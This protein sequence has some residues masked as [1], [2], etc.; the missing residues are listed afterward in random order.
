MGTYKEKKTSRPLVVVVMAAWTAIIVV[1]LMWNLYELR[2]RVTEVA[3][4]QVEAA[5]DMNMIYRRWNNEHGGIY[6]EVTDNLK[7]NPYMSNIPERDI[8]TPSGKVLTLINPSFMMRKVHEFTKTEHGTRE[9]IVSLAPLNP[10]NSPDQ[11]EAEVLKS[12]KAGKSWGVSAVM[13][14][15][16]VEQMRLIRPLIAEQSCIRCHKGQG[17]S[18]G[19][20]QGAISIMLPMKPL[21][22]TAR[23]SAA[24]F[25]YAHILLWFLGSGSI[26]L[27][28]MRLRRAELDRMRMADELLKGQKLESLGILAGG[29][30]HDYNNLLTA[31]M[32]NISFATQIED[33]EFRVY[34]EKPEGVVLE[35]LR[36]AERATLQAKELTAQLITF[37]RGGMPVKELLLEVSELI[38]DAAGFASRGS[39]VRCDLFTQDDLW[40]VEADKSQINQV[41]Q[42]LIINAEQAMLSGGVIEVR[43]ENI[44]ISSD[45]TLNLT[46]GKYVK[47]TVKD[48]GDG[49]PEENL[50]KVFD[51]YFTTKEEGSGLGLAI[52]SSI[53]KNHNGRISVDSEVGVGTTFTIYLPASKTRAVKVAPKEAPRVI[54]PVKDGGRVLVMDDE[55]LVRNVACRILSS[56]GYE[57]SQVKDGDEAI[58]AYLEAKLAERPFDLVIMDLTIPGG[59]GGKETVQGLLEIDPQ[60]KVIVSSGYSHDPIMADFEKYGFCGVISKPY[61]MNALEVAVDIALSKKDG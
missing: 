31:I 33:P 17:Y 18:E 9:R 53:I 61:D 37:A 25:I 27:V 38:R 21:W 20:V 1:S 30:A 4:L 40:F 60:A 59:M 14:I 3:R 26:I 5:Y 51:P 16:G 15:D 32:A 42:N 50:D 13:D 11:W 57:T 36:D 43:A 22:A 55:E 45:N 49:I 52:V 34:K 39:N 47:I 8:T 2:Q 12:I 6:V 58:D 7:P 41:L 56:A 48:E 28:A 19:D 35:S 24:T 23:N 46:A 10:D 44:T 29:I 54:K